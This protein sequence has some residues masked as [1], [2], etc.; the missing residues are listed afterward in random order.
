MADYIE[1]TK[2]T[3]KNAEQ[4]AIDV[5]TQSDSSLITKAGSV[6][7]ELVIRPAA[8][9]LSWITDNIKRDIKQYSV[10]YL[11]TSQLTDNPIADAV[12]SNYFVT[13]RTGTQARGV[14]TLTLSNDTLN[15]YAG[16]L[17]TVGGVPMCTPIQYLITPDA[18][19][20]T[21]TDT[22]SYVKSIRYDDQTWIA[23]ISVVT[24]EPGRIELPVGSDVDVGFSCETLLEAELTSPVTGGSNVETDAQLM[25]RAEYNT[26]EAG[27][28]TYYGIKKKM[29]K[30][31]VEVTGLSVIAGEDLPLF[32]AR[33][34]SV[35]INPGGFVDC[36]VKTCNQAIT[37][38]K[39]FTP[40]ALDSIEVD[41]EFTGAGYVVNGSLYTV[42][43]KLT[44]D[45]C[46]GFIRIPSIVAGGKSVESFSVVYGTND[47]NTNADGARLSS[48]QIATVTF[49]GTGFDFTNDNN[50]RVYMT[51][52]PSIDV[53][54]SYMDKDT[55][56][57]IGQDI[58]VKA[59]VPVAVQVDCNVKSVN[60]LTDEDLDAIKQVIADYI[61]GLNVGVGVINFS[62]IRAAV[63]T[64]FPNVDLRLPCVM[65]ATMYTTDGHIDTFYST[66]GI[67]DITKSANS[68]YWGY[69]VCF[70]SG[71]VDNVRLNVI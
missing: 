54:Q 67:L 71:L 68:N 3:F 6:I 23:N 56:H 46:T 9:L 24:V 45:Y 70:F 35:N 69:Q 4:V 64:S 47:V 62:D 53:L 28:G 59:A 16:A 44:S 12:A 41:D 36:H 17:F 40:V 5:V 38:Y 34:N 49:T 20:R 31:P 19:S 14:I 66:A 1:P 37:G 63:I 48:N 22:V 43:V 30:A 29:T 39:D 61:N 2:T 8:Y 26:A 15:L 42:I 52:M 50:V 7:R 18:D 27:I 25:A 10:E 21:D 51:Y 13:R 65:T 33:F 58:K 11:K 32:R 57:F 55:E 60:A